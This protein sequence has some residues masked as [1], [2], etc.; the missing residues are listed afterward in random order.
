M[1]GHL[2]FID[3]R[4]ELHGK[5]LFF[6]GG[7][8]IVDFL[9]I[10][11]VELLG[12]CFGV[13]LYILGHTL[14]YCFLEAVDGVAAGIAHR[15]LGVFSLG[16]RL[17]YEVLRRS[18]VSGGIERRITSPLFSGVMPTSELMMPRSISLNIAFPKG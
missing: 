1:H 16:L 13:L 18:S 17:L 12:L 8:E 10:L 11:V 9:E 5:N 15:N 14:L 4:W 3:K 6:F 2:L 7:E